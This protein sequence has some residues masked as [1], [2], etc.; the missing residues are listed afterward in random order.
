MTVIVLATFG[1]CLPLKDTIMNCDYLSA[2]YM[3]AFRRSFDFQ[4]ACEINLKKFYIR[5]WMKNSKITNL[6]KIHSKKFLLL[7]SFIAYS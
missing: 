3:F 5:K 2:L 6:I 1:G 7:S 4:I